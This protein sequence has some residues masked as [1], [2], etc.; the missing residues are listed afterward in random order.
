LATEG[1]DGVLA[2]GASLDPQEFWS[3]FQQARAGSSASSSTGTARLLTWSSKPARAN[4]WLLYAQ[5]SPSAHG[6]RGLSRGLI[7]ARDGTLVAW[8]AQEGL[9]R[10]RDELRWRSGAHPA[11]A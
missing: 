8:I 1:V 3:I 10:E 5:D 6:A 2:G 4:E 11:K 9:I 7:F